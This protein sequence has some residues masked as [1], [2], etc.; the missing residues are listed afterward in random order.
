MKQ[1]KSYGIMK[2]NEKF[3][4][5][6]KLS[7]ALYERD[8][9]IRANWDWDALTHLDETENFYEKMELPPF[10]HNYTYIYFKKGFYKVYKKRQYMGKFDDYNTAIRFANSIGGRIVTVNERYYIYKSIN[11]KKKFFGS[12]KT[13]EDAK[14]RRDEL[15]E[16]GWIK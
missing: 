11:G 10:V 15:I 16:N 8:Q 5:Y 7:D 1:G 6:R 3:G 13:L 4:T 12:F 2:N 14:K 9:L